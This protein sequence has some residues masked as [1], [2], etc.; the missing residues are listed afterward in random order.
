MLPALLVALVGGCAANDAR[1]AD[2]AR[3]R[4]IGLSEVELESCLGV[5]DQH[6]TFGGTDVLTYYATSSSSISYSIPIVGGLGFSNGGYCHAT[7]RVDDGRVTRV[8]YSGEK[9]ATGGAN[10]YCVP[11]VRSCMAYLADH[12]DARQAPA[13]S[14]IATRTDAPA[15]AVPNGAPSGAP[16]PGSSVAG[17]PPNVPTPTPR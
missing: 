16:Q 1:I 7:F 14:A 11:I 3:T 6:A 17:Y 8:M 13:T 2:N 5:P 9:N 10:A 4:L 12:P 15:T